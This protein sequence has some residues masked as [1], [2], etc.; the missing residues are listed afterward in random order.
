MQHKLFISQLKSDIWAAIDPLIND[1]RLPFDIQN[2]EKMSEREYQSTSS[3]LSF[4]AVL[5]GGM[6]GGA[7]ALLYAPRSGR[8]TREYLLNEGQETADRVMDSIRDAQV[9]L[10]AMNQE[11]RKRLQRLQMIAQ[12]T[13]E[14]EKEVFEKRYGQVKDVIRE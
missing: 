4:T 13:I 11:T 9:R 7:I 12:E 5:I 10:E 8:E 3:G 6:I 1:K 14:E 2:G